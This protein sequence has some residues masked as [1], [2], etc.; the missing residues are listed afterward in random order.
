MTRTTKAE[1]QSAFTVWLK[2]IGGHEA[3]QYNDANGYRLDYAACYGGWRIEQVASDGHGIRNVNNQRMPS[4][5]F[6]QALNLA[7][8]SIRE[9][10]RNHEEA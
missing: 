7:S 2:A 1:I 8:E 4:G 5:A 10:R 9:Y 3:I 6:R